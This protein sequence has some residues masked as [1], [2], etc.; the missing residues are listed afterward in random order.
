M[1]FRLP[2]FSF[3][4]PANGFKERL[5]VDAMEPNNDFVAAAVQHTAK[6]DGASLPSGLA[7][8]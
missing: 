2:Q 5:A 4:A 8:E 6:P 1:T 7:R 3:P